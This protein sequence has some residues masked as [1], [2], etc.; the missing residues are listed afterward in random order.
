VPDE[1]ELWERGLLVA[2]MDEAGRGPIAGPVVV[3][4]VVFKP[5][6]ELPPARD[7]KELSPKGREVL[8]SQIVESA[9]AVSVGFA[10]PRE[11]DRLNV[12]EA[13][14]LAYRRAL[15]R[16]P[17]RPGAVITDYVPL[18]FFDGEVYS[19][20]RADAS[21]VS[22]AA[23]SVVA[24]VVRDRLMEGYGARYPGFGFERHKGYPTKDH[25]R[26]LESRG[27]LEIHRRSF[28]PL[29]SAEGGN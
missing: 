6:S 24:K 25:L 26:A 7:S 16:L 10:T 13:T 8:F 4:C 22:V 17:F 11:I 14:R 1:R 12:Y 27:A 23:A 21:F 5:F 18:P 19:P 3:A 29:R 2:G 20:P 28:K 9:L 15:E